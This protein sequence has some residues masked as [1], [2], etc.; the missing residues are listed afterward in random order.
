M[1]RDELTDHVPNTGAANYEVIMK[2]NDI[3][4]FLIEFRMK[5]DYV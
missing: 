4:F 3:E 2:N 5:R 1:F